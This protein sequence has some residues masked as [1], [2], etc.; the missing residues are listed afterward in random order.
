M[1]PIQHISFAPTFLHFVL[2]IVHKSYSN[3]LIQKEQ[4]RG[5]ESWQD[6]TPSCPHGKVHD[7]NKPWPAARR[8][9][10]CRN[11][12]CRKGGGCSLGDF[13]PTGNERPCQDSECGSKV[14]HVFAN[15][16]GKVDGVAQSSEGTG[17]E[18]GGYGDDECH[19]SFGEGRCRVGKAASNVLSCLDDED[20]GDESGEDLIGEPCEILDQV[21][22]RCERASQQNAR[23]PN[24]SPSIQRQE[25]QIHLLR[26]LDQ[27]RHKRQHGPSTP[28]NR[29]WLRTRQ[30]INNPAHGSRTNHLHGTNSTIGHGT[31]ERTKPHSRGKAGEE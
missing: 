28:N 22:S 14:G 4:D 5:H 16:L 18:V 15:A 19:E 2:R 27:S 30:R 11:G 6:C 12:K 10:G 8:G 31:K 24:P 7:R 3:I 20:E 1:H 17:G 9:K 21:G 13:G 23:S 26:Q 25:R 29:Q